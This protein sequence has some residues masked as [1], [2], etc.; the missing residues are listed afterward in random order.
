MAQQAAIV[1]NEILCYIK[2]VRN[3]V[4]K[5]HEAVISM[6]NTWE[7]QDAFNLYLD[8]RGKGLILR[9]ITPQKMIKCIL[10]WMMEDEGD[11][12]IPNFVADNIPWLFPVDPKKIN[13]EMLLR[14]NKSSASAILD[15]G[16]EMQ[17][18]EQMLRDFCQY[19][20]FP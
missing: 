11:T 16:E 17:K 6:I 2:G 1:I 15:L 19:Y 10:E 9:A 7:L 12:G 5:I 4:I 20:M 8:H 14:E 3:T 13:C 18:T